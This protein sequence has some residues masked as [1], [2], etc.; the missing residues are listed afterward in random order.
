MAVLDTISYKD[1]RLHI[2]D[3]TKLPTELKITELKTLEECFDAIR[4]LKVRGAPAIG[5][6]AAYSLALVSNA[7]KANTA[8]EYLKE[9]KAAGEYLKTSRPTAVNLFWAIDRVTNKA[10]SY[11]GENVAALKAAVEAEA[12]SIQREDIEMCRMIGEYG[13]TLL[14][15]GDGVLTHCNAGVLATSKYGTATAP[16]YLAHER[17]MKLKIY[18]DETR[19]LLQGARMTAFELKEAGLDVTLICDNMAGMVMSQGKIQKVITGAD[20]IAANGDTANKIGTYSVAVL[21]RY[22]GIPFYIAAPSSTIDL[23]TRTG[24]DIKIEQR[25]PEEITCGFGRR[26]APEGVKTY[27]PAFDV[28]PHSLISGIITEKGVIMPPF[29][30][31]LRKILKG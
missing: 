25:A 13:L 28:T 5:V 18:A 3:C 30:E 10:L 15:D 11:A 16:M 21:A 22:H 9:L 7:L 1:G 20:R 26:T 2:I 14:S 6:A 4:T 23:N 31:N 17:G 8:E 12:V 27:N 19:P 29:G 24:A